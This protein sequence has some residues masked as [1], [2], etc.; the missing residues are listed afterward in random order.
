MEGRG[1]FGP[2]RSQRFSAHTA[3]AY[4]AGIKRHRGDRGWA[5]HA[6]PTYRAGPG[7]Q[8]IRHAASAASDRARPAIRLPP[9]PFTRSIHAR[10]A[11]GR[12]I[13]TPRPGCRLPQPGTGK[14][15]IA[16]L[17]P[18]SRRL[19]FRVRREV[20]RA[21]AAL[22]PNICGWPLHFPPLPFPSLFP[23][24]PLTSRPLKYN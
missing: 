13:I 7:Q 5:T 18:G 11:P 22:G 8:H 19:V 1:R 24:P 3:G 2:E 21:G 20:V 15:R 17:F 4:S 9:R 16:L 23:C 6:V 12:E 14:F 10:R